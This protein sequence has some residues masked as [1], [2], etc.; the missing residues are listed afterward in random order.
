MLAERRMVALSQPN[1]SS[2][3]NL[4]IFKMPR[5]TIREEQQRPP[6]RLNALASDLQLNAT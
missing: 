2:E 5:G 3:R 4:D 6:S 1:I